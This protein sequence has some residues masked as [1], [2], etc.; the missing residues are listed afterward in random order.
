MPVSRIQLSPD[1][2]SFSR[3]VMGYWRLMDWGLST[4]ALVDF[5][6]AGIELGITTVDHADIYGSYRVEARFGEALARAPDVRE[7]I[8]IVTKCGIALLDPERPHHC[9]KHYDTSAAH[10]QASVER[11]L[12]NLHTDYVDLLLIHRPDPLMDAD[13][14]AEAFVTLQAAGKVR[15]FGVSNFSPRQLELLQSRLPFPLVTNQLELS[16]Y[17]LAPLWNGAL[18]QCQ[19]RRI[20]PMAWSCLGGGRL[21][22]GHDSVSERL[23]RVLGELSAELDGPSP[24][25]LVYAWVM[26]HPSHPLP[27]LGSQ[28]LD[29]VRH[30]IDAETVQLNRQQ[31]FQILQAAAG[32]EVA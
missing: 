3:F 14:V 17:N 8:E 5:I 30:A 27:L 25:Q 2:P 12:R 28:H 4:N 24:E 21:F 10:I 16:P 13:Q 6:Q 31:W 9:I 1:G 18:D 32:K 11:S 15:H 23:R 26:A 7:Q 22:K 29:R 19:Q 20:A